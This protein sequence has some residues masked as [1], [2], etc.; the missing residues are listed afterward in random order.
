[1]GDSAGSVWSVDVSQDVNTPR[2]V[3]ELDEDAMGVFAAEPVV[4]A[5]ADRRAVSQ[6][7]WIPEEGREKVSLSLVLPLLGFEAC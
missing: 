4:V 2:T 6:F 7:C 5:L 1:M 3:R